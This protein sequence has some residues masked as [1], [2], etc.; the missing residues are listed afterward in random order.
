MGKFNSVHF[1]DL[2]GT[3]QTGGVHLLLC[4]VRSESCGLGVCLDTTPS[5]LVVLSPSLFSGHHEP[6]VFALL[7]LST[8]MFLPYARDHELNALET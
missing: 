5:F 1:T 2:E 3:Q 7:L 6:S 4:L 8:M